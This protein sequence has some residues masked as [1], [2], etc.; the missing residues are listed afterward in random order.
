MKSSTP[1][2]NKQAS[3]LGNVLF[4]LTVGAILYE[5]RGHY[6]P[7]G[8]IVLGLSPLLLCIGR[9]PFIP[10]PERL[11]LGL[12]GIFG[13]WCALSPLL[14]YR[15]QNLP[16]NIGRAALLCATLLL[17]FEHGQRR[18]RFEWPIF[19]LVGVFFV[20]VPLTS[21]EPHIDIWVVG[22][23]GIQAL[24]NGLNPYTVEYTHIYQASEVPYQSFFGYPPLALFLYLPSF[25]VLG[26]IRFTWVV[27]HLLS[28]VV[29]RAL[30]MES[31]IR[32]NLAQLI[33]FCFLTLPCL[34]FVIE[35]SWIDGF[36]ILLLFL[37]FRSSQ[38]QQWLRC[39]L[40]AALF[41]N[42]KQSNVLATPFLAL[43][44]FSF[45]DVRLGLKRLAIFALVIL[46]TLVVIQGPFI[47]WDFEAYLSRVWWMFGDSSFTSQG[48]LFA[49]RDALSINALM[50][51][52]FE[53]KLPRIF[54]WLGWATVLGLCLAKTIQT[55]STKLVVPMISF[56]FFAY[57]LFAPWAFCNYY[58]FAISGIWLLPATTSFSLPDTNS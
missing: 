2:T 52:Q 21:P 28:A 22:Q 16:W 1:A 23:Q 35:Q 46:A 37:I 31:G 36:S 51:N 14:I 48:E 55:R 29:L 41:L 39:A 9:T 7:V 43:I 26:D 12:A 17:L 44:F 40:Y 50:L 4:L 56:A 25:V 24:L 6:H 18:F 5:T 34:P 45:V 33:V 8:V 57:F 30:L 19:A 47:L 3:H 11:W 54:S 49:R 27:V 53:F 38:K 15:S 32:K 42:F 58:W 20:C 10:S 13:L